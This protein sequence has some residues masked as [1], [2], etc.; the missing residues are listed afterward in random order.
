MLATPGRSLS[1]LCGAISAIFFN[2]LEIGTHRMLS[3]VLLLFVDRDVS[4]A[5]FFDTA[6]YIGHLTNT[7]CHVQSPNPG[8]GTEV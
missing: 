6:F 8:T 3:P 4:P 7:V 1:R 5:N 2:L